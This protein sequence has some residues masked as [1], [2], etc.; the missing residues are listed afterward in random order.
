M[1][2]AEAFSGSSGS[3][4]SPGW[5]G[6]A[7]DTEFAEAVHHGPDIVA[8]LIGADARLRQRHPAAVLEAVEAQAFSLQALDVIG[9][10]VDADEAL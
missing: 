9:F 10:K 5:G 6:I 3:S 8:L 4:F 7:E 2:W 1:S